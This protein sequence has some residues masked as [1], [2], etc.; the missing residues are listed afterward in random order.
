MW[1]VSHQVNEAKG[2][3]WTTNSSSRNTQLRVGNII[4][5]DSNTSNL[6]EI[7]CLSYSI[8]SQQISKSLSRER[9]SRLSHSSVENHSTEITHPPSDTSM[10]NHKIFNLLKIREK[11]SWKSY[12]I[13]CS[14]KK[15]LTEL[16]KNWTLY[17][18]RVR[19]HERPSP[20][21]LVLEILVLRQHGQLILG[22]FE[23]LES[24]NFKSSII[25]RHLI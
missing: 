16:A 10:T 1:A 2:Q 19:L 12:A 25:W 17:K 20:S 4:T 9:F 6:G 15:S 7:R 8:P 23:L 11:N 24:L 18:P 21:L 22:L 14:L 13:S 3:G 5:K